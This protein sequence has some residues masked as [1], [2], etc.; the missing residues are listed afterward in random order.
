MIADMATEIEASRHLVYHAARIE[1]EG[2]DYS[3]EAAMAKLFASEAAMRATRNA[4]QILGGIGLAK[5]MLPEMLLRDARASM[6]EDGAND[7]L[8]LAGFRYLLQQ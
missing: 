7:V 2:G 6:I 3:K 4:I 5:E 8:A 1:D